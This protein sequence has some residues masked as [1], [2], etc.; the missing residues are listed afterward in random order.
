MS[1]AW[2]VFL[3]QPPYLAAASLV[4]QFP[5]VSPVVGEPLF[6]FHLVMVPFLREVVRGVAVEA[7]VG[8]FEERVDEPAKAEPKKK[9]KEE[10]EAAPS[11]AK[12]SSDPAPEE[13]APPSGPPA[14]QEKVRVVAVRVR[15]QE[16][17][18]EPRPS[19]DAEQEQ[20]RE[21]FLDLAA[22]AKAELET[23]PKAPSEADEMAD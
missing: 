11:P 3:V 12:E 7:R 6:R 16:R 10:S 23:A 13:T 19:P 14:K 22:K 15:Q 8:R 1:V 9:S 21:R 4:P 17:P 2:P 18:P 20:A 5:P